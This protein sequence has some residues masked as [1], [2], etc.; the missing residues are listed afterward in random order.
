M[1]RYGKQEGYSLRYADTLRVWA[2]VDTIQKT[3]AV[4]ERRGR[5]YKVHIIKY[6]DIEEAEYTKEWASKNILLGKYPI[7][8]KVTDA[9]VVGDRE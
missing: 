6:D 5:I 3:E 4:S 2:W 9:E 8:T 1:T 7:G